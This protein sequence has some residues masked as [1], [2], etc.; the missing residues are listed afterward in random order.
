MS[1]VKGG[2]LSNRSILGADLCCGARTALQCDCRDGV[3]GAVLNGGLIIIFVRK[4]R[5]SF[6]VFWD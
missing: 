2:W 4:I 5:C 1:G 3:H 6:K